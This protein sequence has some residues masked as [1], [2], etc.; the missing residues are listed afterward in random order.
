MPLSTVGPTV[1][2]VLELEHEFRIVDAHLTVEPDET[3][4]PRDSGHPEQI[5]REMHQAGLV[6]GL[7]V[8]ATREDPSDPADAYVRA[9]NAVARVAVD[10]PFRAAARI[11]GSRRPGTDLPS[12]VRNL[13]RRGSGAATTPE[14]VE[15]YAYEDRFVAFALD[16]VADG[17]P[18]A[19]VLEALAAVDLPLLTYGGEG[20]GPSTIEETLL[21]YDFP[22][23][24]A[25]CGGY[26]LKESL[27]NET[28]DLLDRYEDCYVETSF[29]RFRDPL[30]RAI[31]EH[32]DR[33]LFGS[34]APTS[35][36]SVAVM[37]ILTL[38]VPADAME[39]VFSKN[40]ERVLPSLAP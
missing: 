4:R 35:H 34:G 22:L 21:D 36:P 14:D 10:R 17:F 1:T 38:D 11:A 7:A 8:P 2:G 29:V 18:E 15:E 6:G 26:P 32:P 16:P 19:A 9:N 27:A 37:E 40:V 31:M 5:E 28:I 33:V 20:F 13:T 24:V 25:H 3:R 12:K 30:E 39:R 23:V